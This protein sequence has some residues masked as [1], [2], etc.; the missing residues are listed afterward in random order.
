MKPKYDLGDIIFYK[1]IRKNFMIV[2]RFLSGASATTR[3]PRYNML[4][5]DTG[6]YHKYFSQDIDNNSKLVA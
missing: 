2:E 3:L 5:L 6:K 1:P 4:C